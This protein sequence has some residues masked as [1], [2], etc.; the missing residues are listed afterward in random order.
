MAGKSYN[1]VALQPVRSAWSWANDRNDDE[2]HYAREAQKTN[3]TELDTFHS[4]T[5]VPGC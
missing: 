5:V 2:I 4:Q 3:T 1:A